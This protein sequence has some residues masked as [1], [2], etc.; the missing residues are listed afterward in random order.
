M[1]DYKLS[2]YDIVVCV[3]KVVKQ[4]EEHW[5]THKRLINARTF[6]NFDYARYAT[7]VSFQQL[8]SPSGNMAKFK[9]YFSGKQKLYGYNVELS[10]LHIG[11]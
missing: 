4:A 3:Y 10:V 7:D 9:N 6:Q 1:S 5:T 2:R 8:N 11:I